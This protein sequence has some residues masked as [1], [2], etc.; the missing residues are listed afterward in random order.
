M[1]RVDEAGP[2]S[3]V[4][5]VIRSGESSTV[6]VVLASIE[7]NATIAASLARF[8]EEVGKQGEVILADAS[9]DGSADRARALFPGLRILRKP[10]GTLAPELWRDGLNAS[11]S[12]LVAFSTA[13]MIPS[14]GWL[15]SL[16]GCLESTGAAAVGGPIDPAPRL[17]AADRAVYLLRY[18][19]Y[20]RPLPKVEQFEPPGDNALYRRDALGGLEALWEAGFW[21]VEIHRRLRERGASLAMASEAAVEFQGGGGLSLA[22]RQRRD[23]A[24]HYGAARGGRM[25]WS[26]RLIRSAAAPLVPAILIRR[27]TATLTRRGRGIGPWLSAVPSLSLLLAAWSAG[28]TA[29]TWLG[30]PARGR[31]VA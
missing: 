5:R 16:R 3:V 27:I 25:S 22:L 20:L 24:R 1:N 14:C 30:P 6:S 8:L 12:P 21:E 7:A 15:E 11:H 10:P 4:N 28:E 29:G 13:Q 2:Q 23:H 31:T 26:E 18:V 9:S 19:N 17:S